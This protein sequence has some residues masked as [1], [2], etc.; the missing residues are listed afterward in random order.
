MDLKKTYQTFL[1]IYFSFIG[2][3]VIYSFLAYT[4]FQN[5]ARQIAP[6]PIFNSVIFM[7]AFISLMSSFFVARFF[8]KDP[9]MPALKRKLT[10]SIIQCAFMEAPAIFGLIL[11]MQGSPP[12]TMFPFVFMSLLGLGLR[13][14]KYVDWERES[15]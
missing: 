6:S 10:V 2:A 11:V 9:A 1:V 13:F 5:K 15:N 4:I 7:A 8:P 14:P 3:V 12:Q